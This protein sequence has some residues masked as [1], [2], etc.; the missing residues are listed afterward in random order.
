LD[1]YAEAQRNGRKGFGS[2]ALRVNTKIFAMIDS[3]GEFVVK[4]P[5]ARVT[6]LVA[7]ADCAYFD[8]GKGKPMK[9][10]LVV[11]NTKLS[12]LSLCKEAHAFV[13]GEN[14]EKS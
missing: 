4:L 5:K 13:S 7:E 8:A 14:N 6:A 10:W 2:S 11:R 9:E 12:C 3:Q 1:D